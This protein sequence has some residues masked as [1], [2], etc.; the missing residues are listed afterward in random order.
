MYIGKVYETKTADE[1]LAEIEM[2]EKMMVEKSKEID[3]YNHDMYAA[4]NSAR[5]SCNFIRKLNDK[6]KLGSFEEYEE[7]V[8]SLEMKIRDKNAG[9]LNQEDE[10]YDKYMKAKDNWTSYWKYSKE[11]QKHIATAIGYV[12]YRMFPYKLEMYIESIEK[13][14]PNLSEGWKNRADRELPKIKDKLKNVKETG[15]I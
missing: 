6:T 9:K 1:F 8:K 12:Y 15:L 11:V 7:K 4:L 2:I 3:L 10:L 14:M 13:E 5:F